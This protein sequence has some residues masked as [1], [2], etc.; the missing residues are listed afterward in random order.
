MRVAMQVQGHADALD[1]LTGFPT[2]S[3]TLETVAELLTSAGKGGARAYGENARKFA[4]CKST[5][6][7]SPTQRDGISVALSALAPPA[8]NRFEEAVNDARVRQSH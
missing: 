6:A 1:H 5:S 8:T 7:G 2:A 4:S 3:V